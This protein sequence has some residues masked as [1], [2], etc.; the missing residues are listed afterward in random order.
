MGSQLVNQAY[1]ACQALFKEIFV[2]TLRKEKWM[3]KFEK[4]I[5]IHISIY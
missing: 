5:R 1:E 2:Y 3:H 4:I